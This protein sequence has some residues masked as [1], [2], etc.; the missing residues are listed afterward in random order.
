VSTDRRPPAPDAVR[1]L[2][3]GEV[4]VEGRLPWSSNASF[5]VTLC[6][7]GVSGRAVYKPGRGERALWDF[8]GGLYRREIAAYELSSALGWDLVPETVMRWDAPLGEGSLQRFVDADFA[9]HYFT[10]VEHDDL[11]DQLRAMAAFDLIANNADRKSGHCLIDADRHVWGIDHG[12]CFHEDPKL[13]TVMWDFAGEPIPDALLADIER[14]AE[15]L[16]QPLTKHLDGDEQ[17]A[18]RRRAAAVVR[19][20]RYPDP[21]PN[22]RPYPWPLV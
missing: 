18:L 16:P 13:R 21:D 8:P 2:A 10:L 11:V 1:L 7:E 4:E 9:E 17:A 6:L 22:M 14:V 3:D 15:K 19:L 12:L 20:G 5:V